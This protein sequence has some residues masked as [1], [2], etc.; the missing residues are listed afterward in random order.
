MSTACL[1]QFIAEQNR[2][3]GLHIFCHG[4]TNQL[5]N[6]YKLPVFE[7]SHSESWFNGRIIYEWMR[8]PTFFRRSLSV[9]RSRSPPI[10]ANKKALWFRL[11]WAGDWLCDCHLLPHPDVHQTPCAGGAECLH[12]PFHP[13]TFSKD[14]VWVPSTVRWVSYR[15]PFCWSDFV[16]FNHFWDDDPLITLFKFLGWV[17]HACFGVEHHSICTASICND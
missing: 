1:R 6:G 15:V 9:W 7:T 12:R 17:A 4:D 16:V 2:G 14:R 8:R 10:A 5:K 3:T 13:W 11:G